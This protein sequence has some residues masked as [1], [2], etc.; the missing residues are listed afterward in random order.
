[1]PQF[2][3]VIPAYNA[4]SVRNK[5][6]LGWWSENVE[7]KYNVWKVCQ[8][9]ALWNW[10]CIMYEFRMSGG[11]PADPALYVILVIVAC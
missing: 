5:I 3:A 8:K 9:I 10:V 4:E 11:S 2:H 7:S 6:S 1:V